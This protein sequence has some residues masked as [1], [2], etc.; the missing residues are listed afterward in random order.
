MAYK[1]SK[2]SGTS[3]TDTQTVL[4][5]IALLVYGCP[6]QAFVKAKGFHERTVRNWWKRAG[7]HCEGVHAAQVSSHPMDL[8]QVQA[9]EIKGKT[10]QGRFWIAMAMM[11]PARLWLGGAVRARRDADLIQ[12][13]VDQVRRVALCRPLLLAVDG[14]TQ[15]RDRLPTRF[16]FALATLGER[17]R[18]SPS[19]PLVE[20]PDRAGRQAARRKPPVD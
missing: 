20:Y 16:S 18:P 2:T 9:D 6:V 5:V 4:L 14:L 12:V 8:G 10:Q 11:V 19:D 3:A 7:K 17:E 1:A 15:L 13:V